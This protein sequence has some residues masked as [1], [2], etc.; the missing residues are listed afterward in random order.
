MIIASIR[1]MSVLALAMNCGQAIAKDA[2]K[3]APCAFSAPQQVEDATATGDLIPALMSVA[4]R[5][6]SSLDSKT[7]TTGTCFPIAL[8]EPILVDGVE[9]IPAGATGLGQVVHAAK[10]RAG[11]KGGEL[12]LAARFISHN[13]HIVPLRSFELKK[14]GKDHLDAAL[15]ASVA[16]PM[17]GYLFSGGNVQVAEGTVAL[18]KVR[19]TV[20]I[21]RA[22]AG[23]G[24]DGSRSEGKQQQ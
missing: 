9:I 5:I 20:H 19:H 15:A 17:A 22:D 18:A 2:S 3:P 13:G 21:P 7:A 23:Q 11:G 12:I 16:L 10:A 6:T 8:A 4:I 14:A 1:F 24:D